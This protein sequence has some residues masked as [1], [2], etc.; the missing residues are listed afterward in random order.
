MKPK[1]IFKRL[2]KEIV[3]VNKKTTLAYFVVAALIFVVSIVTRLK[4]IWWPNVLYIPYAALAIYL[5]LIA[6][7]IV[8][9]NDTI[10][11][12]RDTPVFLGM[13]LAINLLFF[14]FVFCYESKNFAALFLVPIIFLIPSAVAAINSFTGYGK[15]F[16]P[17]L[18]VILSLAFFFYFLLSALFNNKYFETALIVPVIGF[19]SAILFTAAILVTNRVAKPKTADKAELERRLKRYVARVFKNVEKNKTTE[20]VEEQIST[21]LKEYADKNFSAEKDEDALY[22]EAIDSLGDYSRLIFKYKKNFVARLTGTPQFAANTTVVVGSVFL[23]YL[24]IVVGS[25]SINNKPNWGEAIPLFVFAVIYP[26]AAVTVLKIIS[27]VRNRLNKHKNGRKD[28]TI[29]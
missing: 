21:N 8:F 4:D 26:V 17:S 24:F 1:K 25:Q 5:S 12:H 9:S 20:A 18:S 19:L 27:V 14:T 22:G 15:P 10:K 23:Y 3:L 29:S 16:R 28:K 7:K 6:G 11:N 2:K 13:I